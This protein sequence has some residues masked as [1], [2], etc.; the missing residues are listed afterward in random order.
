MQW[1]QVIGSWSPV[2]NDYVVFFVVAVVVF[3][4]LLGG[5]STNECTLRI[6]LKD[7]L[8]GNCTGLGG[9]RCFFVCFV[10][11]HGNSIMT[12][13]PPRLI[14]T[15]SRISS[16]PRL[17]L[18]MGTSI[19]QYPSATCAMYTAWWSWWSKHICGMMVHNALQ[20][21]CNIHTCNPC[22]PCNV[23]LPVIN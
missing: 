14:I 10:L 15:M 19:L 2:T 5:E 6:Y 20:I 11:L 1:K 16:I 18:V 3:Y 9:V 8:T 13:Q 17:T 22:N 21:I 12:Q 4:F 7:F 23:G